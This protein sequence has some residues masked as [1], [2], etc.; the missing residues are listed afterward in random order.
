MAQAVKPKTEALPRQDIPVF[1][2]DPDAFQ[3]YFH[4]FL[5]DAYIFLPGQPC[6]DA[7][8]R[9]CQQAPPQGCHFLIPQG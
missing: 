6:R 7:R 8:R 2:P 9:H 1:S 5:H 4:R 3:A